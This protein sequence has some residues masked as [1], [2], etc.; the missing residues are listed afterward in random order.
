MTPLC[1]ARLE[2]RPLTAG[3]LEHVVQL[4]ADPRVMAP[5]G[6]PLTA[7]ES[8]AWLEHQLTHLADHGYGRQVVTCGGEF[9]GLVGLSRRDFDRGVVP[10]IEVAWRL[11]FAHW[12]HGYA[13]EAAFAV[14]EQGFRHFDLNEVI[15]VT[16]TENWRSRR[17]MERLG[18]QA[19]PAEDFDHPLLPEGDPL[20]AHVVYRLR[21]A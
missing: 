5:L 15:A 13:T 12:G 21:R 4:G 7:L 16:S 20:S 6:G 17:V 18:M 8:R 10:G 11:A 14:I 9:V 2:L 3:D 19:S 1:T